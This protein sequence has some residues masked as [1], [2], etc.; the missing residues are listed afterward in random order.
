M[1]LRLKIAGRYDYII[2]LHVLVAVALT[3]NG[4]TAQESGTPI[5]SDSPTASP[6]EAIIASRYKKPPL[7]KPRAKSP[8]SKTTTSKTQTSRLN[9]TRATVKAY[10]K[11]LSDAGKPIAYPI[12]RLDAD[13]RIGQ[14]GTG[15]R[16]QRLLMMKEV[17]EHEY[18]VTSGKTPFLFRRFDFSNYNKYAKLPAPGLC[19]ITGKYDFTES[20]G[21]KRKALIVEPLAP[22]SLPLPGAKKNTRVAKPRSPSKDRIVDVKQ[23]A[24]RKQT[25]SD[26]KP[27]KTNPTVGKRPRFVERVW[28]SRDKKFSAVA[29]L[30]GV[31]DDTIWLK[32]KG[33]SVIRM[34]MTDLTPEDRKHAEN[35]RHDILEYRRL[36][37]QLEA[38]VVR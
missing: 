1:S 35:K 30:I 9:Q 36:K 2:G 16:F 38:S 24:F 14:L 22:S 18:L 15:D 11:K 37:K 21:E 13:A 12:I 34:P 32:V 20:D 27:P 31:G 8:A 7:A 3:T 6:A 33:G 17:A 19:E 23:S 28:S 5:V 29:K 25:D 26:S 10:W 4:L